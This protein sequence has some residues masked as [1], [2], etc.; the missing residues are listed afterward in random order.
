MKFAPAMAPPAPR[1]GA[2]WLVHL[3]TALALSMFL[4]LLSGRVQQNPHLFWT[5]VA[6]PSALLAWRL[7]LALR[8]RL[9]VETLP[10]VR[11]HYV[12]A[13]VQVCLYAFWG[14]HWM[15]PDGTR[16][17]YAQLPLILAQ[18]AF[19]YAFDALFAWT[20]GRAWRLASGPTPIV[21]STNLFIWFKDD[22][23]VWQF[24]MVAA[25]LLGKEFVK[26]TKEGR[27]THIFNPSGFGLA[28]AATVLIATG[29][30]D[31]TWVK[32][33]ATT[34]EVPGIYLFLFGLGLVVQG[35]FRVTLMTFAAALAMVATNLVYTWWTGVYLF[36]STNLPAAAFLGLHLLMTDPSTSPRTNVGR[37]L[38]GLGYGFGYVVAYEVLGAI[39]APEIY[40]KL[41]PVPVLNCC[42]QWLDRLAKSG[43]LGRLNARWEGAGSP[44]RMNLV[45][46]ALWSVVFVVL[47]A[48]GYV[49][50]V[51]RTPHRGDSIAFW[52]Q[53]QA[54][55]RHDA[56]RKLAMVA[57]SLAEVSGNGDAYN[58]LGLLSL[59]GE[60]DA[61]THATRVKSAA[62]WFARGMAQGSAAA[63]ENF[64]MLSSYAERLPDELVGKALAHIGNVAARG[65][66]AAQLFGLV[67]ETGGGVRVDP[68]MAR[69]YYR[70][71]G[72]DRWAR[73]GIVRLGLAPGGGIDLTPHADLVKSAAENG[74]GECC[75]Y[76]ACMHRTGRGVPQDDAA[77]RRWFA[78]AVEL[79]YVP[80][81]TV[82]DQDGGTGVPRFVTPQRRHLARPPWSSAFPVAVVRDP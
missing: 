66:R 79:G 50:G 23:F 47:L 10:P 15:Q 63:H 57:G 25:G 41:Y 35:F 76:L 82:F 78:R 49:Y 75:Y 80:A 56:A 22:W 1:P 51:E 39:G 48:T 17:I 46:M 40:A 21:L 36:A 42:V 62:H 20:R 24:A 59:G 69:H 68:A 34:I 30:S 58:E 54:E 71:A 60:V 14:Y 81:K 19:L 64:L 2:S 13:C 45:H 28:C 12:Q 7:L 26:W 27:R 6:V 18:F 16:P 5:F 9:S 3:P 38:F 73:L 44:A 55:G 61:A 33:L 8:G 37:T 31:L 52:K 4:V 29:T 53:A 67:H 43:G 77:A 65:G 74:D 72:D 11:Q 32:P 70:L